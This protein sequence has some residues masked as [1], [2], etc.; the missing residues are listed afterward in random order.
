MQIE[1]AARRTKNMLNFV[2]AVYFTIIIINMLSTDNFYRSLSPPN[3]WIMTDL[4]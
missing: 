2:P 4:F 1:K 3:W